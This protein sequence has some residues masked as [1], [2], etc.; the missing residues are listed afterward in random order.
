MPKDID[1]K[2]ANVCVTIKFYEDYQE[3]M[4]RE[5]ESMEIERPEN[6]KK[7]ILD[8]DMYPKKLSKISWNYSFKAI[9][10]L[11]ESSKRSNLNFMDCHWKEKLGMWANMYN[12]CI[13]QIEGF[14]LSLSFTHTR[15][16]TTSCYLL[17]KI[18]LFC[19]FLT[20][21]N[22]KKASRMRKIPNDGTNPHK[23]IE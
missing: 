3:E 7:Q 13:L 16:N 5:A 14:S 12:A 8:C 21:W 22:M 18:I 6:F 1:L 17:I 19:T 20:N 2:V 9:G 15:T 11:S 10:E 23:P 4:I